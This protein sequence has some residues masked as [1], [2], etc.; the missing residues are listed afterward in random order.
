MNKII[1]TENQLVGII[2]GGEIR[3]SDS[4]CDA[5]SI[6]NYEKK[7]VESYGLPG[8]RRYMLWKKEQDL[9]CEGL[10]RSY[11]YK[12]LCERLKQIGLNVININLQNKTPVLYVLIPTEID[13]LTIDK[14]QQLLTKCG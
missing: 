12:I 13:K 7:I 3:K 6:W 10:I 5:D 1:I 2:K 14:Y 4:V 11:D 8:V 9:Q